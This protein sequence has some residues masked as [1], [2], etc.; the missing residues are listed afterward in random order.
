[1]TP[2]R[3]ALI[4]LL[5]VATILFAIG[6][7]AERAAGHT[8]SPAVHAE[9]GGEESG[10]EPAETH[11]TES[12]L[13]GVDVES[14]PAIALAVAAGLGLALLTATKLGRKRAFLLVIAAIALAWAA[15]DVREVAHQID[16]SRTGIALVAG[17]VAALHLAAAFVAVQLSRRASTPAAGR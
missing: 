10:A 13:L 2:L 9:E 4:A 7:T 8:E 1:M 14:T 15:L 12:R 3:R 16:E 17:A 5:A 6:V 11:A